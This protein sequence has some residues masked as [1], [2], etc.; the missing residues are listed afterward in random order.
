LS[1]VGRGGTHEVGEKKRR[2]VGHL[3]TET[4]RGRETEVKKKGGL[5]VE[6]GTKERVALGGRNPR[7]GTRGDPEKTLRNLTTK[8]EQGHCGRNRHS[9]QEWEANSRK[10]VAKAT[11][12]VQ[13]GVSLKGTEEI[14]RL[15]RAER[16]GRRKITR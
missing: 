3:D 13:E 1:N 9:C 10:E 11:T 15:S 2:T 14:S 8:K 6:I 12:G 4:P 5:G 7:D 16:N